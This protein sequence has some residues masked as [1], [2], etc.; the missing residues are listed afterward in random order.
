MVIQTKACVAPKVLIA[1]LLQ[2]GASWF[3][4]NSTSDGRTVHAR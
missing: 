2:V 4:E 3:A 1:L